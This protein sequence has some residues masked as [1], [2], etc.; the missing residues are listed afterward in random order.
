[1][2]IA[3]RYCVAG[4]ARFGFQVL[5]LAGVGEL[6]HLPARDQRF[7]D[8]RLFGADDRAD[9]RALGKSGSFT[10][11]SCTPVSR[12]TCMA[13][14]NAGRASGSAHPI[15]AGAK[16]TFRSL[17]LPRILR[18]VVE[19]L[20]RPSRGLWNRP[21]RWPA[22][23]A[24]NLPRCGTS[25]RSCPWSR[26]APW[27]R[28]GSPARRSGRSPVTPQY[29]AGVMMDPDVSEPSANGTSPAATALAG[30][31]DEPPDHA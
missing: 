6:I 17:S 8:R 18:R 22:E 9:E 5:D 31:L 25:G 12:I 15:S 13:A 2:R 7:E 23:P 16:P 28:G 26:K 14:S 21:R 4:M 3:F 24:R 27:R 30:P 11:T 1:M 19:A 29:A 10:S 20:V